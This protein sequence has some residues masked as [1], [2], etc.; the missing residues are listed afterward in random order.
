MT[1]DDRNQSCYYEYDHYD[2]RA[3]R[4]V[5]RVICADNEPCVHGV[6]KCPPNQHCVTQFNEYHLPPFCQ[7]YPDGSG[8]H[9]PCYNFYCGPGCDCV[10]RHAGSDPPIKCVYSHLCVEAG[11]KQYYDICVTY[12]D[13]EGVQHARC[14]LDGG[15]S[16]IDGGE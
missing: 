2:Q 8:P 16:G 4:V 12:Y 7:C 6:I 11:C 14:V 3:R 5:T 9:D 13:D 15:D 1:C 10:P